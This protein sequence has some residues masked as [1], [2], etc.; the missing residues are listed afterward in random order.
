[1]FGGEVGSHEKKTIE[2]VKGRDNYC[3]D[4]GLISNFLKWALSRIKQPDWRTE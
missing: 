3:V 2:V 1:M 4:K